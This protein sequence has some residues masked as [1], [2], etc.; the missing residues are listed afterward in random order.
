MAIGIFDASQIST[1]LPGSSVVGKRIRWVWYAASGATIELTGLADDLEIERGTSGIYMPP[2]R[3]VKDIIPGQ[4]GRL[5]RQVFHDV[6]EV[7]FPLIALPNNVEDMENLIEKLVRFM[8]PTKGPGVLRRVAR[9]GS[10]TDLFCRYAGGLEVS[11]MGA[12]GPILQRANLIFQADD[13]YWYGEVVTQSYTGGDTQSW[14]PFPPLTLGNANVIGDIAINSDSDVETWPVW[15][16]KGPGVNPELHNLTTEQSTTMILPAPLGV[17]DLITIDTRPGVKS[18]I[19]PDGTSWRR[20]L[21]D[22]A[23]WG[24]VPGYNDISLALPD[25]TNDSYVSLSY[26]S[27]LLGPASIKPVRVTPYEALLGQTVI[28][29]STFA[30]EFEDTF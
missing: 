4:P 22:R 23:L 24:L 21:T 13:P 28:T 18:V 3:V 8:D 27:R 26:R 29:P 6:R 1:P 2:L 10:Y 19:G 11:G 15:T 16:I 17:S 25:A 20:Y 9:D 14:F 5:T 7:T 12:S 30:E